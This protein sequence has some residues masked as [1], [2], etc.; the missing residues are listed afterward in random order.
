MLVNLMVQTYVD[1]YEIWLNEGFKKYSKYRAIMCDESKTIVSK[2]SDTEAIILLFD[3]DVELFKQ[4]MK[5]EV[6]TNKIVQEFKAK[7]VVHTFSPID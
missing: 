2:V 1:N 4:H 3:V 7:H 6:M 5:N